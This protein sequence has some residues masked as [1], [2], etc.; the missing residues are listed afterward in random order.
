MNQLILIFPLLLSGPNIH[1]SHIQRINYPTHQSCMS[2]LRRFI[3]T[4]PR[5]DKDF[6]F[7][8]PIMD[9]VKIEYLSPEFIHA[10]QINAKPMSAY[11]H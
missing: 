10:V 5:V 7:C 2:A 3:S 11:D 6:S 1:D 8:K 9:S 4:N